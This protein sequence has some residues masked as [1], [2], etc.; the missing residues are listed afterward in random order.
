MNRRDLF[1]LLLASPFLKGASSKLRNPFFVFDNGIGRGTLPLEQQAELAR[2]TGYDGILFSGVAN[3]PEMRQ[4]LESRG[5]RMFGIYTGMN[6]SAP[7]QGFAPGLPEAI[8]QLKGSGAMITFTVNGKHPEAD[9]VTARVVTQVADM[10]AGSGLRVAL[11]PHYGMHVARIEDALRIRELVARPNLGVIFNLC[12][13]LRTGD[14][15]NLAQRIEQVKSCLYMVNINGCDHQGDW[16]RLIQTLDRGEFDVYNFLKPILASGFTGPIG[17]QCYN[18]KGDI[19]DNITRSMAAWK[20]L[21]ARL[22]S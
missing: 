9:A 12:H 13:W 20:K 18:I 16:D 7:D 21:A 10:A 22:A 15:A 11:Y 8:R 14:E 17:L 1:S 4:D 5:L 6:L 19:E 2:K 3:I